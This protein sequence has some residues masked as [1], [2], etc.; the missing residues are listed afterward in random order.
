MRL[1]LLC[2]FLLPTLLLI[3]ISLGVS[4]IASYFNTKDAVEKLV[5]EEVTRISSNSAGQLK[6]WVDN[7]K[8][9]L[10]VWS[11]DTG[12]RSAVI[13][14]SDISRVLAQRR[15]T[16][17]QKE[18][19]F[20][21]GIFLVDLK[22][23]VI[24]S[25]LEK[26][27]EKN[28]PIKGVLQQA[29]KGDLALGKAFLPGAKNS[30]VL[31]ISKPVTRKSTLGEGEV[32]GAVLAWVDLGG[33]TESV[34]GNVKVAEHG[35]AFL[36]D[37]TGILLFHQDKS[38][39]FKTDFADYDFG[40]EMLAQKNGLIEYSMQGSQKMSS[41][42]EIKGLGWIVGAGA[43]KLDLLADAREVGLINGGLALIMFILAAVIIYWVAGSVIK[44]I[45]GIIG[46][47]GKGAFQVASAASHQLAEG[48]SEQA[49]S[50]EETSAS[51]AQMASMTEQNTKSARQ[52]DKLTSQTREIVDQANQAMKKLLESM[53][54]MDQATKK[55]TRIIKGIDEIAFQTNLLALNVAVEAARAGQAGAGFAV[56]ADEVRNLAM[57]AAEAAGDTARLMESNIEMIKDGSQLAE[58][59]DQAFDQV[60]DSAGKMGG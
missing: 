39:I 15:L 10:G 16:S 9:D 8:R 12:F 58:A 32:V 38:L 27:P 51:L 49:A 1:N 13:I 4:S 31:P 14:G 21:R 35:H 56:V 34:L 54:R 36:M 41:F 25:S 57:R 40:R 7:R 45:K 48:A 3:V 43:D 20:Y 60:A 53:S 28:L 23:K 19:P 44:P 42:A 22:D 29:L 46:Y 18:T 17:L 59:T 47:L 50:L 6:R 26:E 52:A 11:T 24:A 37:Q 5:T 30:P 2:R 33:F 55:S